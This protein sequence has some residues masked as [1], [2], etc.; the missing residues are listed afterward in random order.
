MGHKPLT[1]PFSRANQAA[2]PLGRLS[3]P[4]MNFHNGDR[5]KRWMVVDEICW[6]S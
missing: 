2:A 1:V 6:K 3:I 5:C 4:S